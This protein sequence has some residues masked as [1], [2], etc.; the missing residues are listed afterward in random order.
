MTTLL[1]CLGALLVLLP[2]WD[3]FHTLWHPRGFGGAA[4]GIFRVV[5]K[6]TRPW[7]ERTGRST[8]L[9]GPLGLLATVLV[10]TA[11]LTVGWAL[12]YWPHMPG[13]FFYADPPEPGRSADLLA[14]L[15]LSMVTLATLG[16][17]D[18]VP[19]HDVLRMLLPLQALIGFVLLTAA[20]SWILQL[21]PAL[22]RRRTLARRLSLMAQS[23]TVEV[24]RSGEV[25][26]ACALLDRVTEGLSQ[27]EV[28]CVQY[29]ESYFFRENEPTQSL[30][31][32]MPF[33]VELGRAA[34]TAQAPEVR[35]A[36]SMLRQVT[37]G[38]A[39]ALAEVGLRTS[40]STEEV[41]RAYRSDHQQPSVLELGRG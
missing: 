11:L 29:A 31:A 35:H 25:S 3:I 38:L 34:A 9:A 15:Y 27:A 1:T 13:G 39:T 18:I 16:F 17:G 36:G 41:L 4:S 14:A 7:N 2:L 37:D 12:I 19:A 32:S 26:V 6:A 24:V 20:I 23:D 8:E 22:V 28:D 10:W 40:G 33:V 21:Y 5:W 30:A